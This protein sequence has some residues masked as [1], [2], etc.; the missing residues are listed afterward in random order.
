MNKVLDEV[1][2][3]NNELNEVKDPKKLCVHDLKQKLKTKQKRQFIKNTII[4]SFIITF[5][6]AISLLIYQSL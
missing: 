5:F 4:L 1:S 6:G 2:K 3:S